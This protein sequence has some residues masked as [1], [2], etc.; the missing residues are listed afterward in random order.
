MRQ[1]GRALV[2]AAWLLVATP[3]TGHTQ[4]F[5]ASQS[6]PQFAIGPLFVVAGVRPDL[7]PVTVSISWSLTAPPGQRAVD[8]DQDL[9]LLQHELEIELDGDRVSAVQSRVRRHRASG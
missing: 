3:G 2:V 1:P 6:H 4:V 9:L 7:G 5:L 8:I